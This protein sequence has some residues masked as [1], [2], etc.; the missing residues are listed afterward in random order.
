MKAPPGR[1]IGPTAGFLADR[2]PEKTL[3]HKELLRV[4]GSAANAF[5]NLATNRGVQAR[6]LL[7]LNK[8]GRAKHV[9]AEVHLGG[10]WVM[11]D[12]AYGTILRNAQGRPLSKEELRD[13]AIFSEATR[14]IP[15]YVSDWTYER[16]V[17][18]RLERLPYLGTFLREGLDRIFPRWEEAFN[19]SWV[20]QRRSITLTI[21]S[22]FL[23]CLSLLA[24]LSLNWYD[25]ERSGITGARAK[26][27]VPVTS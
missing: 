21:L 3:N 11:V 23:F 8:Q 24:R 2:E 6:R 13:A 10:R 26:S 7:L 20:L 9:V 4:C 25:R 12:P 14:G 27:T 5:I 1:D 17:H 16:T 19:W 15:G 18:V 22:L